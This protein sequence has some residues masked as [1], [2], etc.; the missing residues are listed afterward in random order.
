MQT[1]CFEAESEM[2]GLEEEGEDTSLH[3]IAVDRVRQALRSELQE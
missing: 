3:A 1:F 2:F